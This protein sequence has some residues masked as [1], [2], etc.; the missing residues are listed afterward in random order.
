VGGGKEITQTPHEEDSKKKKKR[1]KGTR[2]RKPGTGCSPAGGKFSPMAIHLQG[3][4]EQK[5]MDTRLSHQHSAKGE[6]PVGERRPKDLILLK[7]GKK[8][9]CGGETWGK[10][11]PPVYFPPRDREGRQGWG[12]RE[13]GNCANV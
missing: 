9:W 4:G 5:Q 11:I 12:P 6:K 3:E 8:P 10:K 13:N 1:K 7:T 2:G